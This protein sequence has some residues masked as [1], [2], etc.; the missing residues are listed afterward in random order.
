MWKCKHCH[1]EFVFETTSQKANHSR[2]CESNPKRNETE[3]LVKAQAKIN[4]KKLGVM[5]EFEVTCKE[6]DNSITVIERELQHP[7]QE[8]YFC[9]R[10]CANSQGGQAKAN[11]IEESGEMRY[12]SVAKR[13]H[14]NECIICGFDKIIDAHHINENHNDNRPENLV[15]LCP[16]HH[17]LYHSRYKNEIQPHI[18]KY[19]ETKWG[20]AVGSRV[21]LQGTL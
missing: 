4:N 20:I 6:C 11:K 13:N 2:W 16:N 5:K 21:P 7:L 12:K 10:K 19:V 14:I 1:N 9:S 17:R 8:K 3:N 15:F 18:E